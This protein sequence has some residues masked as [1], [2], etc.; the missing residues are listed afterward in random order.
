MVLAEDLMALGRCRELKYEGLHMDAIDAEQ[1]QAA[2]AAA[3]ESFRS[4]RTWVLIATDLLVLPGR[5]GSGYTINS[6]AFGLLIILRLWCSCICS[7]H[8][9]DEWRFMPREDMRVVTAVRAC[10]QGRGMDFAV[11][12]VINYDFPSS[13]ADYV[14]RVG[15]TGR[16]GRTGQTSMRRATF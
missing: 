10:V 13:T 11:R 15:R 2:R 7:L 12:S 3:V 14:H 1:S 9:R 8:C 6:E 4:G 5:Q 16:A